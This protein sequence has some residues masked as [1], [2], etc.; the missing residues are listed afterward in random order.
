MLAAEADG[1]AGSACMYRLSCRSNLQLEMESIC[2]GETYVTAMDEGLV[3]P[4][5]AVGFRSMAHLRWPHVRPRAL[6]FL[7][8]N[9]HWLL[10]KRGL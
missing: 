3:G 9:L 10:E 6:P 7:Q 1:V 4:C 2:H 8:G 5:W